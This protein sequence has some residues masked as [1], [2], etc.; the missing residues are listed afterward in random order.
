LLVR[1]AT[2]AD[3]RALAEVH[4][5]SWRAAYRGLVPDEV[6]VRLDVEE[7]AERWRGWIEELIVLVAEEEG[8]VVG[9]VAAI[10]TTGEIPALYIAPGHFREGIG[11]RLLAAAHDALRAAGRSEAVLWVFAANDG[12]RAFYA[13]HSYTAD[14]AAAELHGQPTVRLTTALPQP[15]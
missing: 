10:G 4:V 6:L 7:R 12:A 9:F 3:A 1:P 11:S 13:A 8:A 15:L 2:P 14:G 5:A